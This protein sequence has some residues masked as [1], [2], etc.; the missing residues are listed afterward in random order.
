MKGQ[1]P[2]LE[3]RK[4]EWGGENNMKNRKEITKRV[5]S[6][7]S[8]SYVLHWNFTLIQSFLSEVS[9]S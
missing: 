9:Y 5:Q 1:G 7:F 8:F 3:L 6:A 2:C 4:E